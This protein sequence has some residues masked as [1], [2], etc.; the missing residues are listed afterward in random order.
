MIDHVVE[1]LKA[2]HEWLDKPGEDPDYVADLFAQLPESAMDYFEKRDPPA[3][4]G[5]MFSLEKLRRRGGPRWACYLVGEDF[6]IGPYGA[7]A[8]A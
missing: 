5:Y 3:A 8:S 1:F 7:V 6:Y 2:L 4:I